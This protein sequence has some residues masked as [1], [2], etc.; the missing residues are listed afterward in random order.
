MP[1]LKAVLHRDVQLSPEQ[2]QGDMSIRLAY[3]FTATLA[4]VR[5]AMDLS[6]I[7]AG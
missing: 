7:Q 1:Y 4:L 5:G 6:E 2:E 3:E